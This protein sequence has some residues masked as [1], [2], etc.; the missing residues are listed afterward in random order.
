ML[1]IKIDLEKF[2]T[3]WDSSF[4]ENSNDE[5]IYMILAWTHFV[6]WK[7]KIVCKSN[8][9]SEC[10]FATVES[11]IISA[12]KRY[13]FVFV[14]IIKSIDNQLEQLINNGVLSKTEVCR[15]LNS[16]KLSLM[17]L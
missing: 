12:F 13:E 14:I 15:Y 1:P 8:Q 7:P 2:G 4:I 6:K 3:V 16:L 9:S 5:Q 17:E 11:I 10:L